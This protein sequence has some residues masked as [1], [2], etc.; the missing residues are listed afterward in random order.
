MATRHSVGLRELRHDTGG[1]LA[2]VQYGETIDVTDR[3]RLVARIVPV[4]EPVVSP[5]LARL[6]ASGRVRR[7]TRPGFR[8]PMRPGVGADRLGGA[9]A[10]LRD[11][12]AW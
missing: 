9:L 12:Q 5:V 3:G 4:V 8:P 1:V 7:A 6:V 10:E 11:E 2:R